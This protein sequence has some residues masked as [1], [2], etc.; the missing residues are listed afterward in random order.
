MMANDGSRIFAHFDNP[1]I[2]DYSIGI[3]GGW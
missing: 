1:A 3:M 2:P